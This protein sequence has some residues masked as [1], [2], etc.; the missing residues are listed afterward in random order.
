MSKCQW[1]TKKKTPCTKEAI[2]GCLY[3]TTHSHYEGIYTPEDIPYLKKCSHC[4]QFVKPNPITKQCP[5]CFK[6][7]P[8]RMCKWLA[9]SGK[10]CS[11]TALLGKNCCKAHSQYEEEKL[12]DYYKC[13]RCKLMYHSRYSR[14]SHCYP[15][16]LKLTGHTYCGRHQKYEGV[17]EPHEFRDL[18]ICSGCHTFFKKDETGSSR[19]K[20]CRERVKH[21]T[22]TRITRPMCKGLTQTGNCCKNFAQEGDEYC[23]EHQSYKKWKSFQDMGINICKNW[24]RGCW[25]TTTGTNFVTC[26]VCRERE[27]ESD[28]K[29][30]N[31]TLQKV[32][33]HNTVESDTR[34]CIGCKKIKNI[35]KFIGDNC[36]YTPGE[37]KTIYTKECIRCRAIMKVADDKRKNRIRTETRKYKD[38]PKNYNFNLGQRYHSYKAKDR[39]K[40]R[41]EEHEFT[42]PQD[43]AYKLMS[44]ACSYCSSPPTDETPNGLDRLDNT[45]GHILGNV[46]PCCETC[47]MMKGTLGVK[48]F[49]EHCQKISKAQ[50]QSHLAIVD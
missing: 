46:V 17:I 47:N 30:R 2:G 44:M 42:L 36:E 35:D 40:E 12:E 23:G 48:R 10:P 32:N 43:F 27:R 34:M 41:L 28:A 6:E 49:L 4:T 31:T 22:N 39:S 37:T 11:R 19:C 1:I 5:K 50:D 13:S 33:A 26:Q 29:R 38:R 21:L 7:N 9:R 25:N 20:D 3:C 18:P 15:P 8:V 16:E 14:C 45:K 24:V